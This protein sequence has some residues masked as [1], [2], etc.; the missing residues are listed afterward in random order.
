MQ[1]E[2]HDEGCEGTASAPQVVVT[3][4]AG[5]IGSHLVD[6]LLA[7]GC[8]VLGIDNFDPWY[9][10][11]QKRSNLATALRH[12]AFRL[13]A[14]DLLVSD[15]AASFAGADVVF[16]LAARPGVQDSWGAG[17]ADSCQLNVL[18]T[19]RVFEA[20]LAAGVGR[21]VYASSSSVYGD[22]AAAGSRTVDPISPYGVSKAAGEQLARVYERQG[23]DVVSLRYFTVFGPRQRPDMAMHRLMAATGQNPRPFRRRGAGEQRREFTYVG[24]V[25]AAAAAVGLCSHG[26]LRG[27]VFDV[28][29]GCN[30]SLNEVIDVVGA[31]AGAPPLVIEDPPAPG[32]PQLTAADITPLRELVGWQPVTTLTEGLYNQWRWYRGTVAGRRSGQSAAASA[33]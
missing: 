2:Y 25:A 33:A 22:G 11:A 28:G 29:G 17:F 10:P 23:L 20:A 19:Q 8:Q 32:D 27:S 18:L 6:Q 7:D 4:A 15:L 13:A 9:N 1:Y 5:F 12:P 24:D 26:G 30:V 31:A 21:V 14:A 16:H 3:G